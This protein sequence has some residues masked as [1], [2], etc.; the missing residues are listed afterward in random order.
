MNRLLVI[1]QD[2]RGMG[3]LGLECLRRGTG[4]RMAENVCEGV[5]ALLDESFSQIAV[6][7]GLLRWP[8][9]EHARL[10][11]RVAPGVPVVVMVPRDATAETRAAFELA[12]FRVITHPVAVDDLLVEDREVRAACASSPSV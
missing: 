5:R 4:L 6:D 2:P 11:E 3:V 9:S 10:F 7:A 12:G 8:P 1:D